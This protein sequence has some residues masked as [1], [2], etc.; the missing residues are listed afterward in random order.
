MIPGLGGERLELSEVNRSRERTPL[1]E[2]TLTFNAWSATSLPS[3]SLH[4]LEAGCCAEDQGSE[5]FERFHFA[6][7]RAYFENNRNI[8][9]R[10]VLL[11]VARDAGLAV[12]RLATDMDRG[13]G[14]AEIESRL[15]DLVAG[16]EISGV[17]TV[18]FG[19]GFPLL[20]AVP[21]QIYECA[22]DRLNI[23][24]G[25]ALTGSH[26]SRRIVFFR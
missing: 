22:A 13:Q 4:A 15:N 1:E 25:T 12:M 24:G 20:G 18:Y 2:P 11:D 10:E 23:Q 9:S 5:A 26:R 14:R 7:F 3:E 8:S 21:I 6:L 17:P 16:G 19:T